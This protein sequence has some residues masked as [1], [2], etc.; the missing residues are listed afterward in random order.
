MPIGEVTRQ[1]SS[2]LRM[3]RRLFS[4]TKETRASIALVLLAAT[5]FSLLLLTPYI[6]NNPYFEVGFDTGVYERV[7]GIYHESNDWRYRLPAYPYT[8]DYDTQWMDKMEP[9]FPVHLSLAYTFSD[10][11]VRVVFRWVLPVIAA[12]FMVLIVFMIASRITESAMGGGIAAVL[13]AGM[14][15]QLEIV[16]ESLYKQ[17]FCIMLVLAMLY[18]L[19]RL[20]YSKDERY[21]VPTILMAGG[22]FYYH[23]ATAFTTF[24]FLGVVLAV[25]ILYKKR[26]MTK[27]L[28]I[29][30]GAGLLIIMPSFI[31]RIDENLPTIMNALTGSVERAEMLGTDAGTLFGG[32]AIPYALSSFQHILIGYFIVFLP[33]MLAGIF[34]I[35][36]MIRKKN[37]TF[38]VWMA[39]LQAFYVGM[40]FYF[41]NRMIY[42]FDI[43]MGI[44][45]GATL[46]FVARWA[47]GARKAAIRYCTILL[48]AVFVVGV[49]TSGFVYQ[50]EK[51]PY[52]TDNLEGVRWIEENVPVENSVIF[53]PD[54]LSANLIQLGYRMAIWDYSIPTDGSHPIDDAEAFMLHAPSNSS[55]TEA[56]FIE[57]PN[58][59]G[60]NLIVLW[61]EWDLDRP[62]VSSKEMIP[63]DLYE[64]ADNFVLEYSGHSEILVIYRYSG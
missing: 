30:I 11:D 54:Y 47:W 1:I 17:F 40:W 15:L 61:G 36:Y 35:V 57:H 31:P 27:K 20:L 42:E 62:L 38:I 58:L 43:L 48:V 26:W 25:S 3:R 16:N 6:V 24:L 12:T 52:I 4:Y 44:L 19:D 45:T 53:A 2:L 60:L 46:Y 33:I 39:L 7:I 28:L 51:A 8:E 5:V 29:I 22:T 21:L 32:G 13:V 49:I 41:G 63:V 59:I 50:S 64:T 55:F 23:Y 37:H 9:G 56:F 10:M 14:N 34:G 18:G